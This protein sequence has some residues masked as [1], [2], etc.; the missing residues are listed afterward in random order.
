MKTK[1]AI[2]EHELFAIGVTILSVAITLSGL[3]VVT[4]MPRLFTAGIGLGIVG[5]G[6]FCA[7]VYTMFW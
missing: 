6:F 3:S 2:L 7:G 5:A 1:Q 4:D